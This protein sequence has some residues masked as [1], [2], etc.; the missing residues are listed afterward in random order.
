MSPEMDRDEWLAYGMANKF[1]GPVVCETHDGMPL[2]EEED[3]EFM[4]GSDPCVPVIRL[5][6][7]DLEAMLVEQHHSPSQWRKNYP[8]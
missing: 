7:D 8:A 6:K 3:N 1:C 2:T 4:E 5:Y